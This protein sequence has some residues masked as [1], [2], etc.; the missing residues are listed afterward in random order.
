[1]AQP[2]NTISSLAFVVVGLAIAVLALR[3]RGWRSRS[4]VFAGCLVATGLGSVAYHGPQ[5]SGAELMHDLSIV[6]VLALIALHDLSLLLPRFRWVLPGLAVF[7]IAVTG[8]AVFA[9]VLAPLAADVLVLTVIVMEVL[10]YRRGLHPQSKREKQRL[11]LVI[12]LLV[13]GGLFISGRTD[14]PSC[15]PMS[16][17]QPHAGW[18]VTAAL[19]FGIWWWLALAASPPQTSAD[20]P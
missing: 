19:V 12:A 17:L 13:A 10:V 2:A 7:A 9:P 6:F 8:A 1:M 3:G 18:H 15:Y 5:P 16:V 11:L 4:M 14:G 20:E